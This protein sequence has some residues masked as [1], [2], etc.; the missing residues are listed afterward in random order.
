ML[1]PVP[2]GEELLADGGLLHNAPLNA[3]V[4][5]GAT[6]IVYLC[7]VLESVERHITQ[8]AWN[9]DYG[10]QDPNRS[11][12]PWERDMRRRVEASASIR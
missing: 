4:K 11:M 2:L 12:E 10:E 8:K 5:L 3:A 9:S 1:P 7:N 6:E